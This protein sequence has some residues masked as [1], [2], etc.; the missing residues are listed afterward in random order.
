MKFKIIFFSKET[1]GG[2]GTFLS[3]MGKL[4]SKLFYTVFYLYKKPLIKI[5]NN[6]FILL[7]LNYPTH[8][9]FSIRKVLIFIRTF[10]STTKILLKNKKAIVFCCDPYSTVTV[11]LI[12]RLIISNIK[13]VCLINQSPKA[14]IN[15]K[16]G[17]IF[18]LFSFMIKKSYVSATHI[19]SVSDILTHTIC[20]VYSIDKDKITTIKNGVD[21]ELI[22][23]AHLSNNSLYSKYSTYKKIIAIGR[24]EI[25]KDFKTILKAFNIVRRKFHDSILILVGDGSDKENLKNLARELNI[26]NITFFL[27]WK[28]NIFKDLKRSD[29]FVFSSYTEGFG[30]VILEAMASRVPVIATD[31]QYGPSELLENGKYGILVPV[32]DEEKMAEK[33][34]LILENNSLRMNY[35]HVGYKRAKE[36]M[37]QNTLKKYEDLF[38]KIDSCK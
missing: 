14:I 34:L 36:Y 2:T 1:I 13:F 11:A 21:F 24:L 17:V 12:K 19:V 18:K 16:R 32:G 38:F 31:T 29:L 33:I 25:E 9:V 8:Y 27:G 6:K 26:Q 37:I 10:L 23:K 7:N 28:E 35:I 22:E 20:K 15:E 3:Q 4:K 30:R 5:P